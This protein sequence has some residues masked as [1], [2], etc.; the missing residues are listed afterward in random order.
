M[1]HHGCTENGNF[2]KEYWKAHALAYTQPSQVYPFWKSN[3]APHSP[4]CDI[5]PSMDDKR[6][7]KMFLVNRVLDPGMRSCVGAAVVGVAVHVRDSQRARWG[8]TAI[9]GTSKFIIEIR[10]GLADFHY[11]Y[12]GW[13]LLKHSRESKK[14]YR[15][16]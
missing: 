2:P 6:L 15:V 13:W 11:P 9:W 12:P 8:D 7:T 14:I 16:E 3:S 4:E 5:W 10:M 1:R